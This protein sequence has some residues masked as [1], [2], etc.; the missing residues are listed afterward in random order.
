MPRSEMHAI[1]TVRS[2]Q[3]STMRSLGW[4]G[5]LLFV[6]ALPDAM[7]VPVLKGL[8]VERY[9][10]SVGSA[11]LFMAVNLI[12]ALAIA[13]VLSR[14]R[15]RFS[16]RAIVATSAALN[17]LLLLAMLM[18][19]G[20]AGLLGLRLVEG[21]VDLCTYATLFSEIGRR[22]NAAHRGR[23]MGMA[24]TCL[25]LGISG[26]LAIGGLIGSVKVAGCL[27]AGAVACSI[28]CL[29]ALWPRVM[30]N[31]SDPTEDTQ[32]QTLSAED[33]GA[34]WP[35][36]LMMFCDRAVAS[37]LVT[38]V[39]LCLTVALDLSASTTGALIGLSML[40][41]AVG[42]WPAGGLV[43][44]FG[45]TRWRLLAGIIFA[46]GIGVSPAV[47][48]LSTGLGA[49][50]LIAVGAAGALLFAASLVLVIDARR[51]PGAM[52]AY[53]AAGNLGF[54]TGTLCAAATLS[55]ATQPDL[56]TYSLLVAGFAAVHFIGNVTALS[57]HLGRP[58]RAVT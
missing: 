14:L 8:V 43:D 12:G 26:G 51:G 44:R 55:A 45:A 48:A 18:P 37:L 19:T 46:A 1:D 16:A 35:A 33:R 40:T 47:F 58:F 52:A 41:L 34:L 11:H 7:V 49:I 57:A 32:T 50:V 17:A 2:D 28:V 3:P 31:T 30:S 22:T 21:A 39:P 38:T 42:A 20:F 54:L 6:S 27:M 9:D 23:S 29:G 5:L 13:P 25:M 36:A 10:V 53:H 15:A 4:L 24:A 56:A